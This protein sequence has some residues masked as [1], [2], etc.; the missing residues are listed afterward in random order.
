MYWL[1]IDIP[2]KKCVVHDDKCAWAKLVT[3]R[4]P[5]FKGIGELKSAGGWLS[6][7]SME[8]AE[9]YWEQNLASKG[10]PINKDTCSC[11]RH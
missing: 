6:F 9:K 2:T 10:F 1:N 8:E 7:P 11:T 4:K 5:E 3:Q